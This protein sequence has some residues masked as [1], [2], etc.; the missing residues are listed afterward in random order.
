M[1]LPL[2]IVVPF[3]GAFLCWQS[4]RFNYK[5]PRWIA[6]IT[7]GI[8]LSYILKIWCYKFNLGIQPPFQLDNWLIEFFIRWIPK[9]G[10]DIHLGVDGL[11]ILMLSLTVFFGIVSILCSWNHINRYQGLF[12]F[13]LMWLLGAIIGLFLSIDLFLFLFFWEI[14]IIPMYFLIILWGYKAFNSQKNIDSANKF[15][16]YSQLSGLLLLIGI[17]TLVFT[18]YCVTHEWT[19]NYNLLIKTPMSQELEYFL[20]FCFFLA[21]IIKI[22]VIPF[23]TWL[24]EVHSYSPISGVLDLSGLLLKTAIYGLLRFS[25]P[26][27]PHVLSSFSKF[28][29][30]IGLIS[31]FYSAWMAFSQ[32]NI[33]KVVAYSS[34]SNM[35]LMLIAIY[36]NNIISFQGVMIQILSHSISIAALFILIHQLY[37][38]LFTRNIKK[39]GGLWSNIGWIPAFF[40]FFII[41]NIG[42]PGTGNF[43]GELMMF[44]GIFNYSPILSFVSLFILIFSS[45]Y[46]LY[47]IKKICFGKTKTCYEIKNIQCIEFVI[48]IIFT[49]ILISIGFFPTFILDTAYI[50]MYNF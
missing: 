19:F 27:F 39:M 23:H 3:F 34:I 9:L 36:V 5:L 45:V 25:L 30:C 42:L 22:P 46:S 40:L 35:G 18:H 31:M 49:L 32:N 15:F 20:M 8:V 44:I 48:L 10:I 50:A 21:F 1:F 17:L 28:A 12:Y 14:M 43:V 6:L 24:P 16:I 4:E 38:I 47:V 13:N 26:F 33:K 2:L 7:M 41:S 37:I 29:I 11:S